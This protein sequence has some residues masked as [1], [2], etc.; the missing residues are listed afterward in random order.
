M[1]DIESRI[2]ELS[3]KIVSLQA[4]QFGLSKELNSLHNELHELKTLLRNDGAIVTKPPTKTVFE[5]IQD[6]P[7]TIPP[8]NG[9]IFF[10]R[11]CTTK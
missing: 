10:T 1:A 2:K 6:P 9:N 4:R 3:E 7:E 8:K 5:V 11:A